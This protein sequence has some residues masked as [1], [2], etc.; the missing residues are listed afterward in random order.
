MKTMLLA[1]GIE[2]FLR[3]NRV[4]LILPVDVVDVLCG[5][6]QML[7]EGNTEGESLD[8]DEYEILE[9]LQGGLEQIRTLA[10]EIEFN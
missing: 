9:N 1:A 4:G 3:K 2:G 8:E 10:R 5:A 6:I 7:L